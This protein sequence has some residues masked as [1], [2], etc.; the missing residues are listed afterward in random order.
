MREL[1]PYEQRFVDEYKELHERMEKLCAMLLNW[2]NLGFEPKC[3][4]DLLSA[5]LHAMHAYID[6][7][8]ER[9]EIEGI[10]LIKLLGNEGR[11]VIDTII[12]EPKIGRPVYVKFKVKRIIKH[13]NDIR[14]VECSD[15]FGMS[16]QFRIENENDV[17]KIGEEF[18]ITFNWEE[19]EE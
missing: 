18:S 7:L 2:N 14:T 10:D 11:E 12:E 9:A 19:D 17:P 4:Y 6:I 1:Q 13:I 15:D 8:E 5:Q 3:S 16:L